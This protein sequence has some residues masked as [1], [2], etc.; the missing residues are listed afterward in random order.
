MRH[1]SIIRYF[2]FSAALL[3]CDG[4][5]GTEELLSVSPATLN[6]GSALSSES[7]SVTAN[8]AWTAEVQSTE[9]D[10][11]W[12]S[13]SKT[14]GSSDASVT[15]RIMENKYAVSRSADVVF[16]TEGGK[17][18][19]VSIIQDANSSGQDKRSVRLKIGTY[20]L[21][22][23][24]LDTE[25]DN[26]WSLRKSRLLQSLSENSFDL[27]G[28]Q[29]VD[30][31]MQSFLQA[32]LGQ[33]YTFWFF[34]PYSQGG[35]GDKAQGI[36]FR[37]DVFSISEKHFFW[38]SETPD[39]C[40]VNDSGSEGSFRRG[41]HCCVLTH[42]ET[43]IKLFFMNTHACLNKE[44]NR[45]AAPVYERM[46]KTYNTAS[47]PSFF[48]GDMNSRPEYE[49]TAIYKAYWNDSFDT[50]QKKSGAVLSYN[51]FANS[52]G[53]YRIDYIFHRGSGITVNE[54]CINSKL[55]D[56]KYASDHFPLWA[57]VSINI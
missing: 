8:C 14:R 19:K 50:A 20:N 21:R 37:T 35:T 23:S 48:V 27:F 31:N 11:S 56:G 16:T 52:S 39:V 22:M 28:V 13:L 9:A 3:S 7:L 15:A 47:L 45:N 44:S 30:K 4:G 17:T 53:K 46:E 29:E 25:G 42:K 38:P 26:I 55:Y 18:A 24:N 12:V 33:K 41:G 57:D 5:A 6:V 36:A 10:A 1:Y 34:S 32:E 49:A 2:I 43:G 40:S 54:F 51:G